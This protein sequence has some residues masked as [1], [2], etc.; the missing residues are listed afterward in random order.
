MPITEP[1]RTA[2]TDARSH[3]AVKLVELC[4]ILTVLGGASIAVAWDMMTLTAAGRAEQPVPT[5]HQVGKDNGPPEGGL[6]YAGEDCG[7]CHTPGGKAGKH[8]FTASGTLYQDRFGSIPLVGAEVIL[9]D[10]RN[11]TL[12][13]TTNKAGNFWTTAQIGSNPTSVAS[14]SGMT[15]LLYSRDADGKLTPADPTDSRT[16]QY[17]AWLKNG[18]A[19]SSMITI[20][21][22]GGATGTTPRMS[23]N[24]H[25]SPLGSTGAAWASQAHA[26]SA[27]PKDNVSFERHV[28]PIM[29]AKCAPCHVPGSRMT[30]L[31]NETDL[32][33]QDPTT[34][35]Y[36][37]G[38]DFTTYAGSTYT[39][40]SGAGAHEE[41]KGGVFDATDP[42]APDE[43]A[44]LLTPKI[45]APGSTVEH[46]GGGFWTK[47][48]ADYKVIRQWI[49]EG[50]K[51]N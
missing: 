15:H 38:N 20:A 5:G 18:D 22:V 19:I 31:V 26:L 24:M 14:H 45:R 2:A 41:Q 23:C 46:P 28:Q 37:D 47:D 27:Y 34:L 32:R 17:K 35:D 43:S 49:V 16:W 51:N 42:T 8:V 25:H 7:I 29:Q 36:S 6:H 10:I 40:G 3:R 1:N 11:K 9:Q 33:D 21:P 30:R 44:L 50:A 12:S 13:M 48:D 4:V 39:I